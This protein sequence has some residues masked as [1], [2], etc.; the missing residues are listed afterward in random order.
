MTLLALTLTALAV[1]G[2][3]T[4]VLCHINRGPRR[5]LESISQHQRTIRALTTTGNKR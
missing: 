2:A 1:T 4:G 3:I 5:D